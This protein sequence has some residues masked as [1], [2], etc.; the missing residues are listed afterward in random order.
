MAI[1]KGVGVAIITPHKDGGKVDFDALRDLVEWHIAEGTDSIVV[2]GTTGEAATLDYDEHLEVVKFVA[3]T[4][5]K[6]IPVIAGTGSN[7]TAFG[8]KLSVEAEKTGVDGLL[9]VTPYY[10]KATPKGLIRHYTAIADAIN[11]PMLLYSVPSRTGVNITPAIAKELKKHKNIQGIKDACGNIS[12]MVEMAR[13]IDD[14]FDMYSGNDDQVVPLMSLGAQGVIST[15][16]N[17]APKQTCEMTRKF[18]AG[19]VKGA[20][21]IQLAQKPLIDALFCEVNPAPVKAA[22]YLMGKCK[23]E[24]RL[25]L[26]EPEDSTMERLKKEMK[27]YGIL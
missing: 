6:R 25:P 4:A 22:L 8:V 27:A 1:F 15:I 26:C 13:L 3:D 24:Y 11:I 21:E 2:C 23:L 14:D 9:S 5:N 18:F 12:Q 17:I 19:D 20:A 16:A 10:N 7:D